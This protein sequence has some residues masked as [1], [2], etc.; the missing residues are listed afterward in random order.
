MTIPLSQYPV[1]KIMKRDGRIVDFD[2]SRIREAIR[3]A[4]VSVNKYD[5]KLLDKIVEHVLVLISEKFGAEK[6]PH[7]E[8]VQDIVELSL[9]KFDQYEV[10]KAYILYR[11]EREKIRKEK[12]R[13]LE[14]DYLDE[15]DKKFSLNALRLISSR[16]LLRG[17]DGKFKEGPKQLFQRVAALIVIPD[18]LY[19][20]RI[21]SKEGGQPKHPLEEFNPDLW[22]GK[23][24]LGKKENGDYEFKWNKWHLYHMKRLYD[25]LNEQ[26]M[27]K[28][29]W[30]I[31]FNM[32]L[33]GEFENHFK[34]YLEYY[35]LM[36]EKKFMPNSPTL[37]NA[38]AR[39]GQL[40]ACFVLPIDDNI[41]SIM[42]AAT[43]AAIIFKSGGGIGINYSKLRPEGDVVFSTSG[44]ASGPVTFMRIIDTVTEVVKQGGKR[45][46]AN[47]GIL[48]I[49]HPDI[50]KFVR[51]KEKEGMLENFNISVLIEPKF[52]KHLENNEPYPL[53]NPRNGQQW[54]SINPSFI[55]N[56]IAEMAWKTADPG[57]LFLDNINRRN[58]LRKV[59]GDIR[60]TN[61]CGEEPLYEYEPCNLGSINLHAFVKRTDK[62]AEIDWDELAKTVKVA[63]RFLDNVIDVNSYPLKDIERMAKLT[64]RIGLGIMGLAD[65]LMA[66]RVPYNS[67]EGFQ[68]MSKIA[69]FIAWHAYNSSAERAG[70]RGPFP[71]YWQSSYP[72]GELPIEGYYKRELWTMNWDEVVDKIKK[73]GIRNAFLLSIAPTGSISMIVD[74]SSGLE[75]VFALV[76]EK[77]VTVGIFH[78]ID[79]EF[80]KYLHESGLYNEEIIKKVSMNGGSIQEL[81]EFPESARQI[82]AVAYDIPWWDHIRAQYQ[83]G[84]WVDAAVSKTINMPHWVSV[85]DVKNSFLFAYKL[86]LKGITIYR[87]ASK[88]AQ[89]L[90]TPTQKL[91]RYVSITKN[92][93]LDMMESLGIKISRP[94]YIPTE[95]GE[96]K[97][98]LTKV[99]ITEEQADKKSTYETC[100]ECNSTNL[101]WQEGCVR[102]LD[103]GWTGCVVS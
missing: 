7:V 39:L 25:N 89:V 101:L 58:V 73:I 14:K 40:S 102:C 24:G 80:E 17:E 4:M 27:M 3:K 52:W 2:S 87:D 41:E 22:A 78:Y 51:A 64:R 49:W 99:V 57:V 88:S 30:S 63:Y 18:L 60:C 28:V 61:P 43:E 50:E 83:V 15:V 62:V 55:F 92:R 59:L 95:V 98:P 72:E 77:H 75:P 85:E 1:K 29:P 65:M 91:N 84:L 100:P 86:G 47:M 10:A 68:L 5:E 35:N 8:D 46:G 31:F 70:E 12:M 56:L 45:R 96:A 19:D 71:L 90:V 94:A 93:T 42:K 36:V 76:Y 21:Y 67:E 79:P 81:P 82:F 103:C 37:F 74:T 44:V 13:I 9:V 38:G 48:E 69:E 34:D 26:G 53:I 11:R 20:S 66:L 23:I 97:R 16:Y 54:G 33:N 32:L 6:I